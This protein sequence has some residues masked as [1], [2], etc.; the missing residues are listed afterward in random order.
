MNT[1]NLSI[2]AETRPSR[3][4]G[5]GLFAKA[6][7][8]GRRKIGEFAGELISIREARRR[9][10]HLKH[11]AIVELNNGKAIDGSRHG[12]GFRHMNHSCSPNTFIRIFRN[13]A[14]FYALRDIKPGE[15]LTCD[16]G[17]SHHNGTR[18]CTCGSQKCCKAI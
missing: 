5:K 12:N 14:E 17:E 6:K 13:L 10:K 16:Y 1:V 4:D 7:L 11:I 8:Q 15:E 9:A 3:I 18:R 2:L